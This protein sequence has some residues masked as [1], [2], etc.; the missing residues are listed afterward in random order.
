MTVDLITIYKEILSAQGIQFR[1]L[2]K[3]GN[4][5]EKTDYGFR[6]RLFKDYDYGD[7]FQMLLRNSA[8]IKLYFYRDDFLLNY[9]FFE[10]PEDLK[11]QYDAEYALIGPVI[12]GF[13][14]DSEITK[15]MKEHR[16]PVALTKDFSEFYN[17]VPS[18]PTHDFW[19][20]LVTPL[21]KT[22][23]GNYNDYRFI[24]LY[25]SMNNTEQDMTIDL[26][27]FDNSTS[28]EAIA[29]RYDAEDRVLDA[30][31]MGNVND[32]ISS[33][34]LFRQFNI[35]PRTPNEVRNYKN[36]MIILNTKLRVA[37]RR[38]K[39]HPYYIDEL[40]RSFAINIENTNNVIQ[41]QNLATTML[42]KYSML[43][44]N[45]STKDYSALIA[46]CT[47][48]IN[49]LYQEKLSLEILASFCNVT[50]GYLSAQFH[51]E[52]GMTLTDYIH[53]IRIR[54]ATMLLNSTDN[55][56][57]DIAEQCGFPDS[58]YFTRIFKKVK[59]ISPNEYRKK[60]SR[61]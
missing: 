16:L 46:K 45:H 33:Y 9:C 43:V 23:F 51:K 53:S 55:T 17:R 26:N 15:I 39:V 20:S 13:V 37:V 19:V 1:L 31:A 35:A 24:D 49:L 47:D 59:G 14:P 54:R 18:L 22:L 44:N 40:S 56:I 32:A 60:I 21:I 52:T 3:D 2:Q 34:R 61:N 4:E 8:E 25:D 12:F 6:Q 11:E 50:P 7:Y 27:A 30:V 29:D 10:F 48:R 38:A 41:L 57:Q 28:F 5:L 58:N 36:W 42:R